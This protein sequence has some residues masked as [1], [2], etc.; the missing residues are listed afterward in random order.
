[1]NIICIHI[2]EIP[3]SY[4]DVPRSLISQVTFLRS[5]ESSQ[6]KKKKEH[7]EYPLSSILLSSCAQ[8][9]VV[10]VHSVMSW[11]VGNRRCIALSRQ[12]SD[13]Q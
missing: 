2:T 5:Y 4:R 10:R 12:L 11:R 7:N 6:D 3:I 9:H 13:Y 1:M 8:V